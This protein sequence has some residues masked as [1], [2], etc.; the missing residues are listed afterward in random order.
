VVI[1]HFRSPWDHNPLFLSGQPKR[2][3]DPV[4]SPREWTVTQ[5]LLAQSTETTYTGKHLELKGV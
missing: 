4:P 1:N 3:S 2:N 5:L